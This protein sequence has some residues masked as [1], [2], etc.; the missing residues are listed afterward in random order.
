MDLQKLLAQIRF[1]HH[2]RVIAL[3]NMLY[4]HRIITRRKNIYVAAKH[5]SA[6]LGCLRL[7]DVPKES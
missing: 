5:S 3:S 7:M 6:A 4:R 2:M 1:K